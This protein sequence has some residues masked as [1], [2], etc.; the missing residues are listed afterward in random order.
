MVKEEDHLN[1]KRLAEGLSIIEGISI[2]PSDV[3]TNIVFFNTQDTGIDANI[4][5]RNLANYGVH[6]FAF[7]PNT[8]RAVTHL[9]VNEN[10]IDVALELIKKVF[11][12]IT[13]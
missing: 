7:S 12:D 6:M 8:I 10:D 1:A 3:E 9:G 13:L 2:F 5:T 4:I 11:S